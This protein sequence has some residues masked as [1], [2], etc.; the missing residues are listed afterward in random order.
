MYGKHPIV[1]STLG[2][3]LTADSMGSGVLR[4]GNVA[5]GRGVATGTG[6][7]PNLGRNRFEN[8][9]VDIVSGGSFD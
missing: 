8:P 9:L 1:V 2:L 4:L 3:L 7:S 5:S 6:G